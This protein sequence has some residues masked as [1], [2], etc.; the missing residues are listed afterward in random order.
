MDCAYMQYI[1]LNYSI[2][3]TKLKILKDRFK[4]L[5]KVYVLSVHNLQ[6]LKLKDNDMECSVH[7]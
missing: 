5:Y 7:K 4:K 6:A 2:F 3:R 1:A